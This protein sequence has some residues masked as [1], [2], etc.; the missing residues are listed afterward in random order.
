MHSRANIL[1]FMAVITTALL[2]AR[3]SS[4]SAAQAR[5]AEE[6]D[7][8]VV[9]KVLEDALPDFVELRVFIHE[10]RVVKRN[11]LGTCTPS[12]HAGTNHFELGGWEVS[13]PMAWSLNRRTVPKSVKD[14]VDEVLHRSF[15]AWFSGTFR[16]GEDTRVRRAKMDGVNAIMWKPLRRTTLG[17]TFVWYSVSSGELVEA[18][19]VFNK[20]RPWAVFANS[21]ECQSSPDAYD[22]QNIATHEFGHWIGLEDL[23]DDADKDLTMYGFG[24]GGEVKKRT[25]GAGD[26]S[27]RNQLEP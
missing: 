22:L 23:Y 18:D 6:D 17:I 13:G 9:E 4:L 1:F 19:T 25:L 24:A 20:R 26:V 3:I 2:A 7:E 15:E 16:Q 12:T 14:D 11:H 5:E 21:P 8:D 27:G 10:P